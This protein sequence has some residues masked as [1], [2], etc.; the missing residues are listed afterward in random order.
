MRNNTVKYHHARCIVNFFPV[1]QTSKSS[2]EV[3]S[4]RNNHRKDRGDHGSCMDGFLILDCVK[5]SNHLRQPPSSKRSQNNN[6]QKVQRIWSE[7]RSKC[8]RLPQCHRN[9][10]WNLSHLLY[11]FQKSSLTAKHSGNDCHN[12]NQHNNSLNKIINSRR[13]ITSQNHVDSCKDRHPCHTHCI[14]YAKRHF[15]EP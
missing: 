5:L 10:T 9:I 12:S 6:S 4:P 11:R 15:K 13:H 14:R 1:K 8:S 7:E 3:T 2:K